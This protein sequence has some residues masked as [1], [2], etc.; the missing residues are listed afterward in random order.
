[1]AASIHRWG[2]G[3]A[4]LPPPPGALGWV[5]LGLLVVLEVGGVGAADRAAPVAALPE[6]GGAG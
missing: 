5:A 2:R 1:M 6:A 4:L 3:T